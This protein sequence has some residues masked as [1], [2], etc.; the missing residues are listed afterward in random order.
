V[1]DDAAPARESMGAALPPLTG[2][3]ALVRVGAGPSPVSRR[4][5]AP[6]HVP[7]ALHVVPLATGGLAFGTGAGD[8]ARSRLARFRGGD[9]NGDEQGQPEEAETDRRRRSSSNRHRPDG[10]AGAR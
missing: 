8:G 9:G 10:T 2:T 1:L 7:A 6:I 5:V 4:R 3:L